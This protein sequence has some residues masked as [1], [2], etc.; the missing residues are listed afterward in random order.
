M[1]NLVLRIDHSF[2]V[3]QPLQLSVGPSFLVVRAC[4]TTFGEAPALDRFPVKILVG[5]CLVKPAIPSQAAASFLE[6]WLLFQGV[7]CQVI[8]NEDKTPLCLKSSS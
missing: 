7:C 1:R 4:T 5:F 3:V 6:M 2:L 8:D